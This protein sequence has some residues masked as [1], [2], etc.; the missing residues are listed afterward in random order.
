MAESEGFEP[1]IPFQV[2]RFSRPVPS[3]TRP[4][5]RLLF[6]TVCNSLTAISKRFTAQLLHNCDTIFFREQETS[7][8]L[9][10]RSICQI[11]HPIPDGWCS[12][13]GTFVREDRQE[14]RCEG[15]ICSA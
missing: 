4:T 11:L 8:R 15:E 13:I 14:L 5:L 12:E 3:T 10:V 2:C 1:P 7:A 6:A 9:R